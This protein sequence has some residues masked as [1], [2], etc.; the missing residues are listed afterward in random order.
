MISRP[1]KSTGGES[2]GR[3]SHHPRAR[4]RAGRSLARGV[5]SKL[6]V[7]FSFAL[8]FSLAL[9]GGGCFE[10]EQGEQFY[11]K[12]V[13]PRSQEFRWSDGGLPRVF[14]PARAAAP[15]DTDVVR[16]LFEGLTDYDPVTLKP[17]PAV[18]SRWESSDGGR[19]WTFHLRRDA[20][21]SNGDRVTARDFV[22]SWQRTLRLGEGAPHAR[23]L[24]NIEGALAL[25]A[26]PPAEAAG[27][28]ETPSPS[29][30]P[31]AAGTP[32]G[33]DPKAEAA[34]EPTPAFGA[35][36][37]DA[38]TL[39]VTLRRPDRSFPALVAH[40]VFRPYHELSPSSDL[41]ALQVEQQNR[42][43]GEAALGIVT[44]G[45][46]NLSELRTE[47]V[48]LERS[49]NYWDSSSVK[50]ERVLFVAKRD[51]EEALAAYRAGEIDA[52]TNA[53]FESLALKLLTP[54][55]DFRRET[56]GALTYYQFNT[57]RAPFDD[58]RVR[59]ALAVSLDLE[60]LSADTLGGATEPARRFLPFGAE[61]AG[62]ESAPGADVG[63]KDGGARAEGEG[64]Q[65][66]EP[67]RPVRRN[68]ERARRL[69]AEA[70]YPGGA[71]FP[72]VRLVV[73][74]N[75]QQRIVAQEIARAWRSALG[76][77]TEIIVRN[78]E[79]YEALVRA[80]DY[81]VARKSVVMQSVDEE[82]NMLALF[83]DGGPAPEPSPAA[84]ETPSGDSSAGAAAAAAGQAE[85]AAQSPAAVPNNSTAILSEAQAL[86]EL[87]AIPI[88]FASSYALVKPY[89][90]GF[91]TNLLDAP[92]LKKVSLDTGWKSPEP[93]TVR[94]ARVETR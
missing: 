69:L 31:E 87:P 78:W 90:N 47:S 70:G 73:N 53:S 52:V 42:G 3:A 56:F 57:A 41:A 7:R 21:W 91:E 45:A 55:K 94:I 62:P 72:R 29:A 51:A 48:V 35:V 36:E 89:V 15:P 83:G 1:N 20:F 93:R 40:P 61:E 59:E 23:L 81:D 71:N 17:V 27:A 54:Y 28:E 76:V 26:P 38:H 92:S 33:G 14:D 66:D 37:V 88:Y 16:A 65:G 2:E 43:E 25:L 82:S 9:L 84:P 50:L 60:R 22:R 30:S 39:R 32:A 10:S 75:E 34:K 46:F 4:R 64:G 58:P 5:F 77:E 86:R 12:V 44:N 74:R 67:V 8:L 85:A 19:K 80:G 68:V 18:A 79:E 63:E 11:G 49:S 24:S 13:A 6:R